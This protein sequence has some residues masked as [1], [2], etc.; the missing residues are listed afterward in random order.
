[1]PE[2]G[3]HA[4]QDAVA[5]DPMVLERRTDMDKDKREQGE[6]QCRRGRPSAFRPAPCP[7]RRGPAAGQRPGRPPRRR[8][9][10]C[11]SIPTAESPAS[12]RRGGRA[13]RPPRAAATRASRPAPAASARA[14]QTSRAAASRKTVMPIHLCQPY[15]RN[16]CGPNGRSTI[17]RPSATLQAISSAASQC[18]AIAVAVYAPRFA[19]RARTGGSVH[20]RISAVRLASRRNFAPPPAQRGS[21]AEL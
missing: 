5:I 20:R 12:A 2:E 9:P 21:A 8:W 4:R 3:Q 10:S 13:P 17:E 14:R 1:M 15:Q 11:R 6:V 16:F 19:G 18:S 7:W